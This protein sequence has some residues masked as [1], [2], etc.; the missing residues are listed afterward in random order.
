VEEGGGD[1]K[2]ID[3]VWS[4]N[5]LAMGNRGQQERSVCASGAAQVVVV[6]K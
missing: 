5:D 2:D 6:K 4:D 3:L 1:K